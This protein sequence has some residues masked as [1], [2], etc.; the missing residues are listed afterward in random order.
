MNRR[1]WYCT[2]EAGQ[3]CPIQN[4]LSQHDDIRFLVRYICNLNRCFGMFGIEQRVSYP[5]NG[6]HDEDNVKGMA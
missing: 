1:A 4:P 3:K 5:T 2:V 6:T